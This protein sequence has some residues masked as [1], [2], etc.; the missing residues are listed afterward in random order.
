MKRIRP[1]IAVGKV[2]KNKLVC[3]CMFLCFAP[4]KMSF[5]DKS[6]V[7]TPQRTV[8]SVA[9][10]QLVKVANLT[11]YKVTNTSLLQLVTCGLP[12]PLICF[13][14][15]GD[16]KLLTRKKFEIQMVFKSFKTWLFSQLLL[17]YFTYGQ[18]V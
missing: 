17:M 3:L 13:Q 11:A 15:T 7:L 14:Q 2:L 9:L 6:E 12:P 1:L 16:K 18:S 5:I 10:D 4:W 8:Q